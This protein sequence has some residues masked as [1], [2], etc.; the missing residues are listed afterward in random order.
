MTGGGTPPAACRPGIPVR[1]VCAPG[2]LSLFD[3]RPYLVEGPDDELVSTYP[4]ADEQP[5]A[6]RHGGE[7]PATP[8][9]ACTPRPSRTPG[10]PTD[11]HGGYR[12]GL[13]R[14]WSGLR[15]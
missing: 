10:G 6:R 9:P 8:P 1:P 14:R 12:L 3:C 4:V 13:R 7:K 2:D 15:R 11:A 5:R